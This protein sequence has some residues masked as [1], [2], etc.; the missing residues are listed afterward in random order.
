[1][2]WWH[3]TSTEVVK[4]SGGDSGTPAAAEI[5]AAGKRREQV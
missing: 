4:K 2:S 5:T 1:M 3:G